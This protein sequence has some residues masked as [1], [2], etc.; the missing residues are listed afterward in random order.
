M[1]A[2]D[3]G[4][5][6]RSGT[7]WQFQVQRDKVDAMVVEDCQGGMSIFRRQ[8]MEILFEDLGEGRAGA[9][10]SSMIRTVGFWLVVSGTSAEGMVY[11]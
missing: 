9:A 7:V 10:S 4:Q 2:F 3:V 5:E 8:D 6:V 11:L 1:G